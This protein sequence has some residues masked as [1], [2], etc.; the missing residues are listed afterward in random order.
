MFFSVKESFEVTLQRREQ[1][2]KNRVTMEAEMQ[3]QQAVDE[4]AAETS[5]KE[6]LSARRSQAVATPGRRKANATPRF[7]PKKKGRLG[8]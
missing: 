7:M 6:R 8:L 2:R 1:Q 4:A 5:L 3:K